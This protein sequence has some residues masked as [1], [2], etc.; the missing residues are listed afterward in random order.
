MLMKKNLC[1]G[2][3]RVGYRI[4]AVAAVAAAAAEKERLI[5][6]IIFVGSATSHSATQHNTSA[7]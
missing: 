7:R 5:A 6:R 4:H 1:M 3:D 2:M